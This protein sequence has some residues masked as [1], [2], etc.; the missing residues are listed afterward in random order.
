MTNK[1]LFI[2]L[3]LPD[4]LRHTICNIRDALHGQCQG[5]P[6]ASANLHLTLAFLG[7][8]PD[9]ALPDI[10]ALLAG[11]PDNYGT[12]ILDE[13]GC[14][15]QQHGHVVWLGCSTIPAALAAGLAQLQ[16]G[17]RALGLPVEK[18]PWQPHITLLRDAAPWQARLAPTL[19]WQTGAAGLYA[20]TLTPQ[21]PSY[22]RIDSIYP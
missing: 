19:E 16:Q 15:R 20:S 8:T 6:V 22:T 7:D 10:Q 1:R 17:L 5:R 21:G 2:A 4:P 14:F 13:L 9:K 12:L 3:P 11:L 18:R